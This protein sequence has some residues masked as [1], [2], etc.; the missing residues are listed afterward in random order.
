MT[1]AGSPSPQPS[2]HREVE[3]KL[4]VHAMFDMPDLVAAGAAPGA[5]GHETFTMR[6]TVP[7]LPAS[8]SDFTTAMLRALLNLIELSS[9]FANS[10][11]ASALNFAQT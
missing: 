1:S 10:A 7:P 6:A 8:L 9:V 4:R 3:R 2:T 5:V 11:N